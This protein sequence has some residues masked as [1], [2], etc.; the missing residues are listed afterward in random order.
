MLAVSFQL[1]AQKLVV[2]GKVTDAEAGEGLPSVTVREKGTGNGVVTDLDGNFKIAISDSDAILIFSFIGMQTI[3]IPV[4]GR[5][6]I[7]VQ[8]QTDITQLGEVVVIGYGTTTTKDATGSLTAIDES[9]FNKGNIVTPENLLS[10]RVAGVNVST[11]GAPG[12]GSTIRIR[13]GSSL[14]ASN[15]PLIVING[16]PIDENSVGGSRSVLSTINPNDIESFTILKDASAT[17]IYGSRA[18]NGVIMITTKQGTDDLKVSLDLQGGM[19][20]LPNKI[21]VFSA[22]EFRSLI[23]ERLPDRVE[24]LGGANTDWQDEIYR[25]A[26]MY[27]ANA[28]VQ[29]TFFDFLPARISVGRSDQEGIR[30]TSRFER[31]T[32]NLNMTPSLLNDN[33]KVNLNANYAN[34]QNRFASGQEGNALIYDPTQ[35]VYDPNSPFGGFF[36]YLSDTYDPNDDELNESDF[37]SLAPFNPV[38]ELLQRRDVSDVNRFYG[39]LKLDYTMPFF[40]SLSATIN[41]GID[42]QRGEGSIKVSNQNPLAQNDGSIIGSESDYYNIRENRLF[43]FYLNYKEGFGNL[44]VD[45]TAGY[46]YQIFELENYTSGE[47]LLDTEDTE[48][49]TT[50]PTDVVLIGLFGR[51]N[52]SYDGK[53]LLTLSFRND[54][55]SRFLDEYRWGFFPAAAFAWQIKE[56]FLKEVNQISSLK[57]RLGYGVTGQQQIPGDEE[58][59]LPIYRTSLPSS[60]YQFG[61]QAYTIGVPAFRNSNLKWEETTSYNI[62]LDYGLFN[63]RFTGTVDYF[64]KETQD[65]FYNATIAEGSNFS[66]AG[67]QNLGDFTV[68]GLELAINTVVFSNSEGFNWDFN[69]NATTLN[70]EITR[71]AFDQDAFVGGIGGGTG[72][73]VQ[74]YRPG[75]DPYSFYVYK[76]LYDTNGDPIEGAYA[77]LNGDNIINNDDKYIYH[78]ATP[79]WNFGFLSNMSYGPLDFTFNI[80]ANTGNYMYNNVNSARA[81]YDLITLNSNLSNI[82]TSVQNTGFVQTEDVILSD[83]Y[84]EDASFLR[85]DNITLGYTFENLL[86]KNS[87]LRVSAGVQNVFT[88][89]NYSGLDPEV[90]GGIDN[91]IYPRARTY[92]LGANIRF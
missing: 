6:T 70:T 44:N 42:Y 12:S 39:N 30:L 35:P 43:D 22:E 60:Q 37:L 64:I 66:N 51:A 46:S 62:G 73:T 24:D 1:S 77:D 9:D 33:L 50:I 57:L 17:A 19:S 36:Q 54:A 26:Y 28:S 78:N 4:N 8:M 15:N 72:G 29:G 7:D 80:R 32:V 18:A 3:E 16:L 45:A 82:P 90:F 61:N 67:I 84:I 56:E 20:E 13:G 81:Q 55:S 48:P 92:F 79:K 49:V 68:K 85:M 31:N 63:E 27:N 40:P 87:S 5:S 59:Y 38:A 10:G 86:V 71:L 69:L 75:Y 88:I 76:Q 52:F 91:T 34:E 53:Y 47:K 41:T 58:V 14:S 83:Y 23:E 2:S 65:L 89:T 25:Q 21:D 74:I 11:G